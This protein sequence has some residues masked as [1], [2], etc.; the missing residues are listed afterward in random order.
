M[1]IVYILIGFFVG[2]FTVLGYNGYVRYKKAQRAYYEAKSMLDHLKENIVYCKIE[3]IDDEIF[4]YRKKDQMF[5]GKSKFLDDLDKQLQ[6]MYPNKY[7]DV[8]DEQIEEAKFI[9]KLN[10]RKNNVS[11]G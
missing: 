10:E 7:F 11:A 9:S 5:L 2:F 1:D 4:M 3:I 8:D 6:K